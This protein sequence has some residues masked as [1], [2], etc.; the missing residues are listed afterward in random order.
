[1]IIITCN[2]GFELTYYGKIDL[3]TFYHDML[4]LMLLI[5]GTSAVHIP[6]GL[7]WDCEVWDSIPF[8]QIAEIRGYS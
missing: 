1:M 8:S 5:G 6:Y 4:G 7:T 2:N 3:A